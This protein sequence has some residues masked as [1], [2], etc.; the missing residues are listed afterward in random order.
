MK[1]YDGMSA[2]VAKDR[3]SSDAAVKT[4]SDCMDLVM[5]M[6]IRPGSESDTKAAKKA[7]G[8]TTLLGQHV[9]I[10]GSE[11]VFLRVFLRFWAIRQPLRFRV[12]SIPPYSPHGRP[13]L[14]NELPDVH[15]GS[16]EAQ[17]VDWRNA[18]DDDP[19]DEELEETPPFV[20]AVL[21]YDPKDI[22]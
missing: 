5:K 7:Y 15:F 4:N 3:Q 19:D 20:V 22:D 2:Q 8:E 12:T 11:S 17:P 10:E 14:E 21:G 16:P 13:Q 1:E 18:P 6:G 9:K